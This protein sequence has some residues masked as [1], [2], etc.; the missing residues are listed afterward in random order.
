MTTP[1]PGA[2]MLPA[3]V[4]SGTVPGRAIH[5]DGAQLA[6]L[7]RAG[8]YRLF[9]K[10]DHLNKIN[11]FPVPDGD[12]G[13]NMAMT[14]AAVLAALDR[15]Q[16]THAGHV[17]T[18]AADAALDGARGNSGAILAQFL[19]GLGDGAGQRARLTLTE[20]VA[21]VQSGA[22]YARDALME[23]REGTILTVLR[24]FA[25]ALH[26][27]AAGAADF[28]TLF[29]R[30]LVAV[31]IAL[32]RTR[33][34]LE[35]LRAADVVDAGAQGFVDMLEGMLRFLQTG[36]RGETTMPVH[37]GEESMAGTAP[38]AAGEDFRFCTECLVVAPQGGSIALRGLRE[39]LS[40][41]GASL[42]VSGS[43]RKAKVHIHCDDP[44]A[45]FRLAGEFGEVQGQKA[46]DMRMQQ[47]AAHHRRI[48]RVAVVT[49]S[50]ADLPDTEMERLGIHMVAARVNFGG[51]SYLD[52]VSMTSTE[53]FQELVRNPEHPKTSQPPPGDFRRIF[54]FLVSHYES[55]VSV[56]LTSRHSG[57]YN[58]AATVAQRVSAEGRPVA[59]VDTRNASV[60]E[61]LVVLA[62][63]EAAAAGQD[64]DAVVAVAEAARDRTQTFA[65]IERIDFAV[66]GGR[67]PA[68]VGKVAKWLRLNVI[69]RTFPDGR[70]AFGGGLFG[71]HRRHRRFIRFVLRRSG[72]GQGG[73]QWRVLV[74]HADR[75]EAGRQLYDG[76]MAVLPQDRIAW[77]ALTDMGAA[78]G[79]HAG[80]GTLIVA[81]QRID[82]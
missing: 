81:V 80:P 78:I 6:D 24:E 53:F 3:D 13:T 34:Q 7:L 46:D 73:G 11:V 16:A 20:F 32:D 56:N 67:V 79:V 35:E 61:A 64:L 4:L 58:A 41:V 31:R 47:S 42:V 5:L 44:D 63:A 43:A 26:R 9:R 37:E 59:V 22:A 14:L 54:E 68:V 74:G 57:T 28:G 25:E 70:V 2:A 1:T 66:R 15:D 21:A 18:R 49:D 69:L 45:I 52:K 10:T 39:S 12:T 82:G 23:P 72:I 65:L 51:R 8:I 17:L 48:Q 33:N 50:G 62:A 36:E 30:S 38:V 71:P 27:D 55:V 75:P 19:L 77:S 76:L 29:E 40:A 60:G